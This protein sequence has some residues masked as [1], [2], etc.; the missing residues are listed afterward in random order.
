M[1]RFIALKTDDAPLFQLFSAC[2]FVMWALRVWTL[3]VEMEEHNIP[4]RGSSRTRALLSATI[5]SSSAPYVIVSF[6]AASF[7]LLGG[8]QLNY[9]KTTIAMIILYFITS[10][11]EILRIILSVRST[12]SLTNLRLSCD[13]LRSQFRNMNQNELNP[14]NLY[15]DLGRGMST[16]MMTFATQCL[17]ISFVVSFA[18][19]TPEVWMSTHHLNQP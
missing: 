10:S 2:S 1:C 15:E 5:D 6:S 16:V 7:T 4:F 11:A 18:N 3:K 9:E 8:F 12:D 17:F 14:T 19:I 13:I